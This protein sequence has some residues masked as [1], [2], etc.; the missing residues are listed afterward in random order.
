MFAAI[1][2]NFLD[3]PRPNNR[4]TGV[5]DGTP[6]EWQNGFPFQH[7]AGGNSATAASSV[8]SP[9]SHDPQFEMD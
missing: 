9:C 8:F 2:S 5:M 3:A 4:G 1:S 6:K 7:S